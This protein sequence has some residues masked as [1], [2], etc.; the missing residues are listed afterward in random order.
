MRED[1]AIKGFTFGK[2][3]V[4]QIL[5]AD[6]L[7][8]FI[9]GENSMN[10]LQYI[11]E[12]YEKIS[13]L[14][15]NKE[16]TYFVWMG[17]EKDKPDLPLFGKLAQK[18]K[19]LG[20]YFTLDVKIREEMNYKEILSKIKRLL[21]WWKQRD[22]TLTGKIHL[23]KTYAL[24][25]LNYVTSLTA[26]PKWVLTE[27][28]KITFDFLWKGKDRI[29]RDI[30]CQDY[31]HGGLRMTQYKLFIKA[32]RINWLKRLLYGDKDMGWKM[33]FDYC[34][35]SVGGRFIFLCDYDLSKLKLQIPIFYMDILQV[36]EEIRICRT[37]DEEFVNPIILN[38]RNICLRGRMFF[39]ASFYEKGIFTLDHILDKGKVKPFQYFLNLGMNTSDLITIYD[40]YN[41]LSEDFKKER[42]TIKFQHI[43]PLNFDLDLKIL[44]QRTK[45]KDVHSRKF[46]EVLV[47]QLQN[48]YSLKIKDGENQFEYTGEETKEIFVRPRCT[49]LLSKHREF[50]Y[51]LLHGVIYT[52]VQLSRFGFVG[53]SLCS[54]CNQ[55]TE[56]YKHVF[57]QCKEVKDTWKAM[58]TYY[59]L[60][61]I[62]NME[63][64]DVFV[65]LPGRTIRMKFVNSLII[66]LKYIIIKR[67]RQSTAL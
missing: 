19:I 24:S 22:L 1:T 31:K 2:Q 44:G 51:M 20:I 57:W 64:K 62:R 36:W 28:E 16:K 27:V 39:S 41:S 18:V 60:V 63:W 8:L 33:F 26:V 17:K 67:Y 56:T 13:G 53:N 11:F 21:G 25:K 37:M 52:K 46:Y 58:I 10:K 7:T 50:Q 65:G 4:K 55:E 54:F 38:N 5:Y 14:R 35:K 42:I 34:C 3:E 29:K 30:I 47:G 45:L 23:M 48:Q 59:D 66:V 43:D 6:D 15:M 12:E 61:E 32:Q 40:I 9:K 49:T